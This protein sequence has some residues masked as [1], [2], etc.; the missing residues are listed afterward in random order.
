MLT[1]TFR[2]NMPNP[3]R[4]LPFL[5]ALLAFPSCTFVQHR[6]ERDTQRSEVADGLLR[7]SCTSH[8]GAIKVRGVPG[9][10]TVDVTAKL[11]A[12][13][14]SDGEAREL[15]ERLDVEVARRGDELVVRGVEPSSMPWGTGASFAFTIEAPAELALRLVTHNGAVESTGSA[16]DLSVV[17]HNGGVRVRGAASSIDLTTHNGAIDLACEGSGALNGSA[18]AHN[19]SVEVDLGARS[20]KLDAATRNGRMDA[21]GVRVESGGKH[22][23]RAVAGDGAGALRVRTHNGSVRVRSGGS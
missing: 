10:A 1:Q 20:T 4:V 12:Y 16:G 5:G 3:T 11:T 15:V 13:A 18:T 2:P 17:T 9:K 7:V 14:K 6:A 8:N 23:L 22:E 21:T 19:G